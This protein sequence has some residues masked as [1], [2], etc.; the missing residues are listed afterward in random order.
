MMDLSDGLG[1]DLNRLADASRVGFELTTIPIAP[2]ATEREALSGG[3]DYELLIVTDDPDRLRLIF[4]DRGLNNP[5][6]IGRVVA[7]PKIRTWLGRDFERL[8]WQHRL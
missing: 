7:D 1:L 4:H 3:E 8:G 2:G 6:T 5:L